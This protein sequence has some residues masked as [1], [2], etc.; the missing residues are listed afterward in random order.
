MDAFSWEG[1]VVGGDGACSRTSSSSSSHWPAARRTFIVPKD[2]C[3][4]C[5]TVSV[6]ECKMFACANKSKVNGFILIW[7]DTS[8]RS[9]IEAWEW[10]G[11][12]GAEMCE[13][14]AIQCAHSKRVARTNVASI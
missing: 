5:A 1:M 9:A 14:R 8:E 3:D 6:R 7:S 11:W 10:V 12:L 2:V 13:Q 4:Y